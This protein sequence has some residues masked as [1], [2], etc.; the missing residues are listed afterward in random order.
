MPRPSPWCVTTAPDEAKM[1]PLRSD[2]QLMSAYRDGDTAAFRELFERYV[3]RLRR[4]VRRWVYTEHAVND[5]VQQT[6]LQIHRARNDY[7]EGA[8]LRPW[9]LTIA[10]NLAYQ[11]GRRKLRAREVPL[12]ET[13]GDMPVAPNGHGRL[14][15][16]RDLG[17][18]LEELPEQ[19]REVIVMHWV[20]GLSYAAIGRVV[21]ASEG[22]VRL[23]AHRGY[24]A[25]RRAL[26]GSNADTDSSIIH[27]E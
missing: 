4:W 21:G 3:P 18:A 25:L 2:E 5:L 15:L 17:R 6:F 27:N 7:R 26:G 10:R 16:D 12:D 1:A 24:L 8:P 20:E 22:S 13:R 14:E 23:R 19:Q 9:V 11:R